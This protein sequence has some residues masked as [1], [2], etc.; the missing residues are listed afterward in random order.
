MRTYL[1]LS[2]FFLMIR[3][4]PRS[5]RTDTLFPYTTLF[6]SLDPPAKGI[7]DGMPVDEGQVEVVDRPDRQASALRRL[8]GGE[9]HLVAQPHIR[10]RPG[11]EPA[12]LPRVPE[13]NFGNRLPVE[14]RRVGPRFAAAVVR[15]P[16]VEPLRHERLRRGERVARIEFEQVAPLVAIKPPPALG[17][18]PGARR[19]AATVPI[20][21]GS[22]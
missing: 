1:L 9:C 22:T 11:V 12:P 17:S 18:P 20:E 5:T 16:P 2:V 14:H 19:H 15:A 3:R 4:P 6:R 13:G 21:I 10:D 7:A 8:L